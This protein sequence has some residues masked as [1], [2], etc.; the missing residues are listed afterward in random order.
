M[1]LWALFLVIPKGGLPVACA[2]RRVY[3]RP[4]DNGYD[5]AGHRFLC[6]D[7]IGAIE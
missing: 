3:R 6:F 1:D 4:V 7:K 5:D 2:W